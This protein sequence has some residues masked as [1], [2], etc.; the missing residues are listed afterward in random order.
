MLKDYAAPG[1][2]GGE[3]DGQRRLRG[4]Q[5]AVTGTTMQKL[6]LI[7]CCT[8]LFGVFTDLRRA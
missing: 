6:A 2:A 7:G 8:V 4:Q 3:L 5:M 1:R